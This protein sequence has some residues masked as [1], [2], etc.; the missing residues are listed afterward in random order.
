LLS[1]T[2]AV[3]GPGLPK[4]ATVAIETVAGD[5]GRMRARISISSPKALSNGTLDIVSLTATVPETAPY[6]AKEVL[7]LSVQSING[8]AAN[9]TSDDSVHVVGYFGDG[10]GDANYSTLDVQRITRVAAGK[11]TGFSAWRLLDPVIIGDFNASGSVTDQDAQMLLKEISGKDQAE[12]PAIPLKI[13]VSFSGPDPLVSIPTNIT[14]ARGDIVA[15]P[16]TLDTAAGLESVNLRIAYDPS[17]LD[18]VAVERG[19]LT[20]DFAIYTE[21]REHGAIE[22]DMARLEALADG[23]GNLIILQMRIKSHAEAAIAIDLQS[24]SLNDGRL[25]LTPEPRLGTDPTDGSIVVTAQTTPRSPR[26]PAVLPPDQVTINWQ[27]TTD[28]ISGSVVDGDIPS[29]NALPPARMSRSQER[30]L[31]DLTKAFHDTPLVGVEARGV[32]WQDEDEREEFVTDQGL[33]NNG[34]ASKW[35]KVRIKLPTVH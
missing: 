17:L 34:S 6:G 2:G 25:M 16:I 28:L 9:V 7:H 12:I 21:A 30:P 5:N 4:G 8:A 33:Q 32:I 22:I 18:L 14:G 11:D 10:D 35:A 31:I 3:A 26:E 29:Q 15:V 19:D 24:A 27:G 23:T 1:I 13:K 20:T